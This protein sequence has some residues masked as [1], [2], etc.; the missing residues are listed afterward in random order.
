MEAEA[1]AKE[2]TGTALAELRARTALRAAG[3]DPGVHL[4]RATS[5]TNEV[6]LTPTH[7]VRVN[8]THDSRL[9]REAVLARALPPAVGY[10]HIV[11]HGG[12]RG[13]DWLIAERV[14]GA[15]LA[16]RWPDMAPGE[17]RSAVRQVAARL[18]ALH[19]TEA[20]ADLP[21]IQGTPQL[22]DMDAPDPAAPLIN[23]LEHA[24]RLEHVDPLLLQEAIDL[25][26][27]TASA[28]P[29]TT[30]TTLVHGDL[31]FENILCDRGDVTALLD[32]EWA[33]PGP[34][35]LDL[36]ILLRCCAYPQ[37]HV[38]ARHEARTHAEDYAPVPGWLLEDYP[39][40][41]SIPDL[42]D[43]MRI[44]S[45]AYDVRELTAFPPTSDLSDLSPLH[46]YH[47]LARVVERRSYLD[48]FLSPRTVRPGASRGTSRR[49]RRT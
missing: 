29:P 43:R 11:S 25:V 35:D 32:F 18:A 38:G 12:A 10:P 36:D 42:L 21:P 2:E 49:P 16:H 26:Q 34:S 39:S 31:T 22:L 15:P 23:A 14:P 9:S 13:A 4:E 3:L 41:F 37:L 27:R 6:W 48:T 45:L 19:A 28:L 1:M 47:R 5:V 7:V 17:R 46:P 30:A 40:L 44:Y 33:R 8:R 24:A 20:P